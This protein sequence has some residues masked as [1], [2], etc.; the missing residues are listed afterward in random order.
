[1]VKT[2]S[3]CVI[4]AMGFA[5][6]GCESAP[7]SPSAQESLHDEGMAALTRMKSVDRNVQAMMDKSYGYTIF[8]SVGKGGLIVG[9]AHGE[10]E[11][12]EQ[13]RFIGYSTL[14][15]AEIGALAGGQ[16]FSELILFETQDAL[17]K[18][19]SGSYSFTAN[20]SAVALKAGASATGNFQNGVA[21]YT[22]AK[23]GVMVEASLSGQKF[24]YTPQ[25]GND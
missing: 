23:G 25:S 4:L 14:S 10:G 18:F 1:M 7:S 8:P 11:V 19:K 15:Q 5:L 6:M 9:A 21:V 17:N 12:Y 3:A 13:G 20:A 2:L 24:T 22:L 16:E